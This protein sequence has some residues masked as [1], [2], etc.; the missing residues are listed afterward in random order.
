[1][2]FQHSP[3]CPSVLRVGVGCRLWLLIDPVVLCALPLEDFFGFEPQCDLLLG[4][5]DGVAAVADVAADVLV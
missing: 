3:R 1:M 4:V 2:C 5:F